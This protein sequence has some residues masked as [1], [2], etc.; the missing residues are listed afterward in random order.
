MNLRNISFKD[1]IPINFKNKHEYRC[2]L[3][4]NLR[5]KLKLF[6]NPDYNLYTTDQLEYLY[7]THVKSSNQ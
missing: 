7:R 1:T 3:K 2:Y 4:R 6:Y 5:R